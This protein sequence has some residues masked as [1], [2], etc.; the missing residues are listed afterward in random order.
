MTS[1]EKN[2]FFMFNM[3]SLK[4]ISLLVKK[5]CAKFSLTCFVAIVIELRV[6]EKKKFM[7]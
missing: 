5:T 2:L 4:K 7:L 1:F 6:F 3:K